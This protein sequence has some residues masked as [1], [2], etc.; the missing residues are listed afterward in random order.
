MNARLQYEMRGWAYWAKCLN[1]LRNTIAIG[2]LPMGLQLR[3]YKRDAVGRGLYRRKVHEP[4]LTNLLLTRFANPADRNFID[5]GANIG[6]FTCLMSKLAGP[7][8]KVLAIEP[9]PQNL[10]LL[11]QNIKLNDLTN[12]MVHSC[13][14][15]A[16]EGSAMLGLYK[17]SNRGRH[18]IV[19][20]DAKTQ[21]KVPVRTLDELAK[22]S[23]ANIKSWSFVK[24]DVEGYEGFVLDG[25]KETLPLI[26]T[27]VMEYSPALLRAAGRDPATT[28]RMLT[29]HFSRIHRIGNAALV[30][31]TTEDC[32]RDE[33]QVELLFDR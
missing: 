6:Y 10:A 5:V 23:A 24:I 27:L 16:S 26:E 9:E 22:T 29:A 30:E 3:A 20:T 8:G 11:Q 31:V 7:A 15:G 33:T 25:A 18:S 2:N 19:D 17:P 4:N 32:L 13:A 12:V 21:I 1:P 28:L 14:L